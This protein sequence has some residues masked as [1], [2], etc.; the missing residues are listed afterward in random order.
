ME[1]ANVLYG[2]TMQAD[3]VSRLLKLEHLED[4]PIDKQ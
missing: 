3:G 4:A 1:E 2:V